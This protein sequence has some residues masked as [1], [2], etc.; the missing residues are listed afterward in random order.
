MNLRSPLE[1]RDTLSSQFSQAWVES[2]QQRRAAFEKK[3]GMEKEGGVPAEK[4]KRF[5]LQKFSLMRFLRA[6]MDCFRTKLEG[7]KC[8][9]QTR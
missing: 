2:S 3:G 7:D 8:K 1:H 9:K 5:S 6:T 4:L